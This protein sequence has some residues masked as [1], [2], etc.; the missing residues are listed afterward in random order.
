MGRLDYLIV[1]NCPEANVAVLVDG[2]IG[3]LEHYLKTVCESFKEIQK[4]LIKITN[5]LFEYI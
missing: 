3:K 2:V 4:R 1:D 5:R